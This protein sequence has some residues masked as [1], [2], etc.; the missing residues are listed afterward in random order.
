[1]RWLLIIVFFLFPT[2]QS[3]SQGDSTEISEFHV[4]ALLTDSAIS[5]ENFSGK[6]IL[7]VNSASTTDSLNQF[8]DLQRLYDQFRSELVIIISPSNSF[9]NEPGDTAYLR[10]LY[11][12]KMDSTFIVTAKIQVAGTGIHSLYDWLAK[13][14]ENGVMNGVIRKDWTKI[15]I[16]EQG[17]IVGYFSN[18]VTP[19]SN[20]LINAINQN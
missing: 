16:N 19:L 3:F 10:N 11:R 14:T 13:K 18:E 1:M 12:Y 5:M 2:L 17:H 4:P 7:L 6:K 20:A 8:L 15:L 9:N